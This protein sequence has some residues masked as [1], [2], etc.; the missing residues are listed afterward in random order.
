M[1]MPKT[2]AQNGIKNGPS[3]SNRPLM[4]SPKYRPKTRAQF[5]PLKGWQH[6]ESV[7]GENTKSPPI[8]KV[9]YSPIITP[10]LSLI[11][12]FTIRK[13]NLLPSGRILYHPPTR[14]HTIQCHHPTRKHT[15]QCHHPTRKHIIQYHNPIRKVV[16]IIHYKYQTTP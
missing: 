7:L 13:E 6:K 15:I 1:R 12:W 4:T 11:N 8:R 3:T 10:Q 5:T 16:M 2:Q 9:R 14:K